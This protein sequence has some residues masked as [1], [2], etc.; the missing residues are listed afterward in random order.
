[1]VWKVRKT[2]YNGEGNPTT[3]EESG[4]FATGKLAMKQ[5]IMNSALE[6]QDRVDDSVPANPFTIEKIVFYNNPANPEKERGAHIKGKEGYD[7]T[8]F[9]FEE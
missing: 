5:C 6:L 8:Y 1:M 9:I 4:N 7:I 2:S 3:I